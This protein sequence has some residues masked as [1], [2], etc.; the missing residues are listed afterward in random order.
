HAAELVAAVA[1]GLEAPRR[2]TFARWVFSERGGAVLDT[3]GEIAGLACSRRVDHRIHF[4]GVGRSDLI[5]RD[6]R[7]VWRCPGAGHV[8][9]W[10]VR[11]VDVWRRRRVC[12]RRVGV[13][14]GGRL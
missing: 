5:A 13:G 14:I 8:W 11:L 2:D 9:L 3:G 6:I 1:R 12:V 10:D 4:G 7:D